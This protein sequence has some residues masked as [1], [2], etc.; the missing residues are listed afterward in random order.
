MNEQQLSDL[1]NFASE[2]S[3]LKEEE[4][5]KLPF[6]LNLVDQLHINENAHSRILMH[7]LSYKNDNGKYVFLTSLIDLI[8][9][10][11]SGDFSKITIE[12][13]QIT[14]EKERI[15]LWVRD[16]VYAI[17]F[18][19]KIYNADD[20]EAQLSNYIEKTLKHNY[21]KN[22]IFVVYLSQYPKEPELQSWGEYKDSFRSRYVNL[23]FCYDILPWLKD[24]ILPTI[25]Y[26]E[27]FLQ[28]AII[29]YID[30]LEGLFKIRNIDKPM[31]MELN[32][33]IEQHFKLSD[34][35][36]KD[37]IRTIQKPAQEIDDLSSQMKA[38]L[39]SYRQIIFDSWL[40]Q[41][42]KNYSRFCPNKKHNENNWFITDVTIENVYG[43]QVTVYMGADY[44]EVNSIIFYCGFFLDY[45]STDENDSIVE[46]RI[47]QEL[48]SSE[49]E[50]SGTNNKTQPKQIFE[51]FDEYNYKD[52]YDVAYKAFCDIVNK[53]KSIS[54]QSCS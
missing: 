31:N 27:L 17:I 46:N 14:Q 52:V 43:R 3:S 35:S 13:P 22:Q 23:S 4:Q 18:E 37:K 21:N 42:R 15:D 24:K 49:I 47:K 25:K 1:L 30:Y 40:E 28:T 51:A 26:K 33:L 19:N 12:S 10:K 45:N 44:T 54:E 7:L 5:K 36:A 9:E 2:F 8:K 11:H 16:K 32:K 41:T 38:L 53:V 20:R 39:E 34:E 6:H 50:L 48:Q 29:Q